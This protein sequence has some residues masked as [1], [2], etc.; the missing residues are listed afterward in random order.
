MKN[1]ESL[2]SRF[3]VVVDQNQ[4]I[5]FAGRYDEC[6]NFMRGF[7]ERV[8][9]GHMDLRYAVKCEHGLIEIGL[10]ASFVL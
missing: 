10:F 4:D 9:R 8:E 3:C 5:E 1:L 2:H 7:R 6:V